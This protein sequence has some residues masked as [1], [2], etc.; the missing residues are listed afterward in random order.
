VPFFF[1]QV[2]EIERLVDRIPAAKKGD[3]SADVTALEREINERV[4]HLYGLTKEEIKMIEGEQ[5][6]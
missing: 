1:T 4:Y 6:K 5:G 2:T 3:S